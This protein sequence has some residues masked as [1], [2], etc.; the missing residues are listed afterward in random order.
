MKNLWCLLDTGF[1]ADEGSQM[2]SKLQKGIF[3][4][5]PC[6]SIAYQAL[7][8]IYVIYKL[9]ES[10]KDKTREYRKEQRQR[11]KA[12]VKEYRVPEK[13]ETGEDCHTVFVRSRI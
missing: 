7:T 1:I 4:K 6:T 12:Q 5:S 11:I 9:E 10:W 13:I 2:R 8:R 3:P